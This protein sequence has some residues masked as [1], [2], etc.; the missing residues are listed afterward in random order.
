MTTEVVEDAQ[1]VEVH[2]RE[3]EEVVEVHHPVDAADAVDHHQRTLLRVVLIPRNSLSGSFV[4][5]VR[6]KLAPRV[7]DLVPSRLDADLHLM[8]ERFIPLTKQ[9]FG[10]SLSN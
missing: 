4:S 1:A 2:R 6:L 8:L 3:D 5:M 10:F 9:Q 7:V